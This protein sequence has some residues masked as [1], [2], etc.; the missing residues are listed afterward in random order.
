MLSPQSQLSQDSYDYQHNG[1]RSWGLGIGMGPTPYGT[2]YEHGGNNG[3]FQSGFMVFKERR[4]GYV[5][6]TN[7]DR[8]AELNDRLR[9]FL[10]EGAWSSR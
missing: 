5:V 10:T 3:D 2:R 7:S 1:L 4:V 6:V 8:G 9:A